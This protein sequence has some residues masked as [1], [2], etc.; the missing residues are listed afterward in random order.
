MEKIGPAPA[1][2]SPDGRRLSGPRAR[3][4]ELLQR[5]TTP[6]TADDVAGQ[7]GLHVNTARKHLEGLVVAGLASRS[8][9]RGGGRGRPP[10]LYAAAEEAEPDVRVRDYAALA[11]V[12]A[13]HIAAASPDPGAD[14]LAAGETWGRALAAELPAGTA[15][16][17]RATVIDL[18]EDLG[19]DP[20]VDR[21]VTT[22]RLRRCPLLDTAR[23][24]P[25]VVCAVHLGLV[26]GALGTLGGDPGSVALEPFA[27]PG[28]CRLLMGR[29]QRAPVR[30]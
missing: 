21:P 12:L 30:T 19:F 4:L 14:A 25:Q 29:G 15:A 2:H 23:A 3:P 9:G 22:V 6:L 28:A 27:E 8:T 26:R 16:S 13:G 18:L 7:L 17:A 5:S 24:F 10:Q 1:R 11:A 20:H